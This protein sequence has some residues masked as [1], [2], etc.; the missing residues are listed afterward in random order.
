MAHEK[1]HQQV[2]AFLTEST[3]YSLH[4]YLEHIHVHVLVPAVVHI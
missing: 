3:E 4:I 2:D 1:I